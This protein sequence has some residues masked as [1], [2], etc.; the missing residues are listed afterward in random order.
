MTHL[1][2]WRFNISAESEQRFV[3]AYRSDGDWAKLFATAP[4][5]IRTEL[6]H[7]EDGSYLTADHWNSL[8][9]FERFQANLGDE[10][11]RLD[12]ELEGVSGVETFIGAFD[13]AD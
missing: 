13:L 8:G 9:D 3:A 2:L 6:W 5:F 12:E 7:A 1:R 4:G 11:R 10:Y